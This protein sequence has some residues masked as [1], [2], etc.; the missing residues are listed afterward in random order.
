V[1]GLDVFLLALLIACLLGTGVLIRRL[2]RQA[3]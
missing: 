1:S 3:R 2:G